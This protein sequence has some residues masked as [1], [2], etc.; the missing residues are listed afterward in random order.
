[1]NV[2]IHVEIVIAA[3]CQT[4]QTSAKK[5]QRLTEKA[6]HMEEAAL[7]AVRAGD[8]ARSATFVRAMWLSWFVRRPPARHVL[9]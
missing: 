8:E 6:L 9:W 1:M 3:F 5:T 7:Q 4:A 2:C